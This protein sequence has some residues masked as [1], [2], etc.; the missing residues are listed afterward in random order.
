MVFVDDSLHKQWE[1]WNKCGHLT[2]SSYWLLKV[3][4]ANGTQMGISV[5]SEASEARV[6]YSLHGSS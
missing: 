6:L 3:V 1:H 4:M 2:S 5:V